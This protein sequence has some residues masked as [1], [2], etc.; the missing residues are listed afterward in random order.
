MTTAIKTYSAKRLERAICARSFPEFLRRVRIQEPPSPSIPGSGGVIPFEL[1]PHL[2]ELAE[3]LPSI[4]LLALLKAR[5][6]GATWLVAAYLD[7]LANYRA[8]SDWLLL[9]KT[10][11]DAADFLGRVVTVHKLLPKHL[12]TSIVK[13][14]GLALG[15]ANGSKMTAM[16]STEDAGRGHTYSGVVQ[17]EADFHPYLAENYAAVKPTVD[18]GGQLIMISTVNKRKMDSLFKAILRSVPDNGWVKR[19]W[20]WRLR[21]G[22]D[23][24]WYKRTWDAVPPS[25][26]MSPALYMEQEYPDNEME[27]LAP[28][29]AMA[30]FDQD[31]LLAMQDDC[32]EPAMKQGGLVRTWRKPVVAGKYVG[33][34]D[35]SWGRAGA[36]CCFVLADWQTGDQVAEIYGR[37][38][39][40]EYAQAIA[41][42]T[43]EYNKAYFGIEANGEAGERG[44]LNVIN[45][46]IALG[47]GDRMYHHGDKWKEKEGQRGWL[48]T[49]I[50][51]PVMLGELEEAVRMRGI[52]PRCREAVGE[53]MSFI[54]NEKGRPEATS[55]AYADH[56]FAWAGTW[57]MRK[58]AKYSIMHHKVGKLAREDAGLQ[59]VGVR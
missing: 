27:A 30:Y 29:R 44:G 16:A 51:R 17:D 53:M 45:K 56:V 15:L 47:V 31:A 24:E 39:H 59:H 40:D 4:G 8:G 50:S 12:S 41:G 54:R 52:I 42:L 36:Y 35:V 43:T 37:P 55:G 28:S 57:Q 49:G 18:V 26:G 19:F 13:E 6:D 1:W 33:F 5:Q 58:Y 10:E 38:E 11:I 25:S 22:R 23:K 34:G 2:I 46:L 7:W 32:R 20:G 21:P 48:T 3:V 9:S 14:S